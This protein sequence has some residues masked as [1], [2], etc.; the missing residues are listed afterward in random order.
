MKLW[1]I[2]KIYK[3]TRLGFD[4]RRKSLY[5][6]LA[7]AKLVYSNGGIGS[8]SD[9]HSSPDQNNAIKVVVAA[10]FPAIRHCFCVMAC[11]G[12][13]WVTNW[14][15]HPFKFFRIIIN[16][17]IWYFSSTHFKLTCP[18]LLLIEVNRW[19]IKI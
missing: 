9:A 13:F 6:S 12:K 5:F 10:V 15:I 7:D 3:I 8:A 19:A 16:L 2:K 4:C 11:V 17:S 14:A 1:N 18:V